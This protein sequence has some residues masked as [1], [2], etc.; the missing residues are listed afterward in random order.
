[1]PTAFICK[2]IRPPF[3]QAVCWS[4]FHTK[5]TTAWLW[6]ASATQLQPDMSVSGSDPSHPSR[7]SKGR[8]RVLRA[9]AAVTR[10]W[11]KCLCGPGEG[12]SGILSLP[13]LLKEPPSPSALQVGAN[14]KKLYTQKSNLLSPSLSRS[15]QQLFELF[16]FKWVFP[17][18]H[19][20]SFCFIR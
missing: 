9:E 8:S 11:R 5:H 14:P 17:L 13:E 12:Q 20:A 3:S 6:G 7:A 1:M 15:A 2:E 18:P 16:V 4:E 10:S 19:P